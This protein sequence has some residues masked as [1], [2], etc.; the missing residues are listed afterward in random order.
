ML[1]KPLTQESQNSIVYKAIG[2]ALD[3][4]KQFIRLPEEPRVVI[5]SKGRKITYYRWTYW[6]EPLQFENVDDAARYLRS[7]LDDPAEFIG[8]P[9]RYIHQAEQDYLDKKL[10]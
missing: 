3:A 8:D 9:V 2:A 6:E 7:I 5:T 4:T 1:R 10:R